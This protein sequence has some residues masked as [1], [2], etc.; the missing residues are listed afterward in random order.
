MRCKLDSKAEEACSSPKTYSGLEKGD[1]TFVVRLRDR[2][3][4]D[5]GSDTYSW[6]I[7][8]PPPPTTT[9]TSTT[10]TT[11]TTPPPSTHGPLPPLARAIVG[12]K[13]NDV[14]RGTAK[15]DVIFGLG[16]NDTISGLGGND[17]LVGGPGKD[18]LIGGV[19]NDKLIGGPGK[20][21]FI[22]GAG[23]DK[24]FAV[25]DRVDKR[26]DGGPGVD[27]VYY[28]GGESDHVSASEAGYG[29]GKI[30]RPILF[31]RNGKIYAMSASGSFVKRIYPPLNSKAN[32][33]NFSKP[34]W[35]P[36]GVH[37]AAVREKSG[38]KDLWM[39]DSNGSNPTL[40]TSTPDLCEQSPAWSPDGTRLAYY[41]EECS[42]G[43]ERVAHKALD[44][45]AAPWYVTG[46]ADF[47]DT[48]WRA[49]GAF[50]YF[51]I[52]R[53]FSGAVYRV[54]PWTTDPQGDPNPGQQRTPTQED[55]CGTFFS[56][57]TT[58]VIQLLYQWKWIDYDEPHAPS[59][60]L[61]V[62][63][64]YA[65]PAA[66]G[67]KLSEENAPDDANPDWSSDG[68]HIVFTRGGVI[69]KMDADGSHR[70]QLVSGNNP[71]WR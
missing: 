13:G 28:D 1:H 40:V 70:T 57:S 33:Y 46:T 49:D 71:D 6:K 25:D 4:R 55:H 50:V 34:V 58:S 48:D 37:I 66:M 64:D 8:S 10:T 59:S 26:I 54:D 11:T 62:K 30:T 7:V 56:L 29:A 47:E 14:L 43:D 9:T 65:S 44:P 24:I 23:K 20:D 17:I 52:C 18:T 27:L 39:V 12:S 68:A 32:L 42:Q 5:L 63:P 53:G 35:S 61:Y 15:A 60:S 41:V 45:N 2:A 38:K 51:G 69:W 21:S 19:G 67:F 22:G 16:G 3:G 31:D 36:D